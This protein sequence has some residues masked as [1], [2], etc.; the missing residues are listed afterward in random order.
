MLYNSTMSKIN[1]KS[2][3]KSN[4]I[5]NG[6]VEKDMLKITTNIDDAIKGVF[7][8]L[9]T[10]ANDSVLKIS[11]LIDNEEYTKAIELYFYKR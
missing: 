2:I 7:E 11:E 9:G 8:K 10:K 5:K 3:I 6:I 1:S 4:N